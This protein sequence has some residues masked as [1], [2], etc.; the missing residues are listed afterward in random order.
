MGKGSERG[1]KPVHTHTFNGNTFTICELT[2]LGGLCDLENQEIT[3]LR[4]NSVLALGSALEEG[5]HA[6]EIP[7]RY[8]HKP[9]KKV[10]IGQSNSKVDDLARF[11]WRLGWRR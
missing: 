3:I 10:K 4:G 8:L 2:E 5:L 7:D 1:M 6:M 9:D 11:L